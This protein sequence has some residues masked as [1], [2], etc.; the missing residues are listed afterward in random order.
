MHPLT[1]PS[2]PPHVRAHRLL[3]VALLLVALVLVALVLVLVWVQPRPVLR[4]PV[5]R[6]RVVQPALL[7]R[8]CTVLYWH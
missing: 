1:Q 6:Q 4:F 8:I 7:Q 3:L 2:I 5:A